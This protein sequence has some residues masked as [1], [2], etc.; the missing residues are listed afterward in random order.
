MP[1]FTPIILNL[2]MIAGS[3]WGSKVADPPIMALG[4]AVLAG[5]ILQLLFQFP[6]LA[7]LDLLALPRWGWGHPEVRR[8]VKLMVPTLIGSSV[9]QI[10][11]LFDTFI[12]CQARLRLCRAGC[13]PPTAS[14]SCRW[15]CSRSRSAR[16]CCRRC[17]PPRQRGP[18]AFSR[19]LD[20]GLRA[21]FLIIVPAMLGL[22]LL[23]LPLVST[24]FQTGRFDAFAAK[25]TARCRCSA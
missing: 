12:G 3:I 23:S 11:L 20:W 5:G 8:V 18:A 24:L 4:W 10:N 1:A 15:A 17:A 21:T 6:Q 14:S 2:C 9:A 19:S 25:M 16:W 13:R 22:M 7:Q